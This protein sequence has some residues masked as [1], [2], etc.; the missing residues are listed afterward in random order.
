MQENKSLFWKNSMNF[1]AIVGLA[2]IV[3]A[4]I[5]FLFGLE[6]STTAGYINY[7]ILIVGIFVGTKQFRDNFNNGLITYAN[8]LGSG[9]SIAFFASLILA[10]YMYVFVT[11]IDPDAIDKMRV[12]AEERFL[13]KGM[14]DDQIEKAMEMN[15]KFMTPAFLSLMTVPTFT[16]FG[17]LFSLVTSA[18]LK[19]EGDP[20]QADMQQIENNEE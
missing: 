4:V 8:A 17:F 14:P 6:N 10:L 2:F 12:L 19:K 11:V 13:D 16:F 20:F 9:T 7:L 3:Y 5:L 18:I 1:G 15:Q